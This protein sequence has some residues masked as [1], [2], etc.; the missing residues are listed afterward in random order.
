MRYERGGRSGGFKPRNFAP[1]KVGD[2][3]E[4][5]IDH[6]GIKGDGIAR[7]DGFVLFV[8]GTKEGDQVKIRVTRVLP[9]VGFAEVVGA[10]SK[11]GESESD[12]E[13][14]Y[15]ASEEPENTEASSE[16]EYSGTDSENFGEDDQQ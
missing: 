12:S 3:L 16:E 9:K 6:V 10:G 7:K 4:V 13:G 14:S 2:E 8:P 11:S 15:E 1:V 5:K